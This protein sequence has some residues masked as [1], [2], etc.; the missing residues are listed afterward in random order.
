MTAPT[1]AE[2]ALLSYDAYASPGANR[3]PL[4]NLGWIRDSNLSKSNDPKTGF[5][6]SVYRN[7]SEIVVAFRGTDALFGADTWSGN[8]PAFIGTRSSQIELAIKAVADVL[9]AMAPTDHLTFTGHSLGGGLASVMAVFFD[10]TARV[11]ALAPF[12]RSVVHDPQ[13]EG[14]VTEF[15]V[16]QYFKVYE[17]YEKTKPHPNES[18][19]PD[20]AFSAYAAASESLYSQRAA[21]VSNI[22][23]AGEAVSL[24]RA[25]ATTIGSS[26]PPI[27]IGQSGLSPRE[28]HD[29][30][31]HSALV[32]SPN[33]R[34][35]AIALPTL[36]QRV[37]DKDL[38][39]REP[40]DERETAFIAK[41]LRSQVATTLTEG[42]GK[43][44]YFSSDARRLGGTNRD[45][46]APVMDGLVSALIEAYQ[47]S[48][49]GESA[50]LV[51][52]VGAAGVR[53]DLSRMVADSSGDL[54]DGK[55]RSILV[56]SAVALVDN[57][58]LARSIACS[59]AKDASYWTVQNTNAGLTASGSS[60]S[61][62][63]IGSRTQANV[64][65]GAAAADLLI[66]GAATDDLSGGA[67]AD[68]LFGKAGVDH[69]YGNENADYL[70]G[71]DN[72]DVLSGGAG[73]DF[74]F[75]GDGIDDYQ[76]L[77]SD[78]S[79]VVNDADG[80]GRIFIG[81]VQF[82]GGNLLHTA[83]YI[84][85][86]ADGSVTVE[87]TTGIS[88]DLHIRDRGRS[89]QVTILSWNAVLGSFGISLDAA[90]P[91]APAGNDII[92]DNDADGS[93]NSRSAVRA[94]AS[95]FNQAN[96]GPDRLDHERVGPGVHLMSDS[97]P[98]EW[99]NNGTGASRS[100]GVLDDLR[101]ASDN[102]R[103]FGLTGN[104][105]LEGLTGD[106]YL[107]GGEDD[108]LLIGGLGSDQIVGGA[109]S[110]LILGDWQNTAGGSAIGDDIGEAYVPSGLS[111]YIVSVSGLGWGYEFSSDD[112][113]IFG[114]G[115]G[116]LGGDSDTIDTGD[117]DDVVYA[118]DG[119][120]DI[121][122]GAGVDVL[123]GESGDDVVS[124]GDDGDF[125]FGDRQQNA[126]PTRVH[127][128]AMVDLREQSLR[129][130]DA[131]FP[132]AAGMQLSAEIVEGGR[133]V[134][135]YLLSPVQKIAS[136]A[137]VER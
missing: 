96:P 50:P 56:D 53:L 93:G 8:L 4:D 57:D 130:G 114:V 48:S 19:S 121:R 95:R 118:G 89:I 58:R 131:S 63:L 47:F 97:W 42:S 25:D 117:G 29:M 120:D 119:N 26:D 20:A 16:A 5:G 13:T 98:P 18:F 54:P 17:D 3:V 78:G 88:S 55:G 24:I 122:G 1:D 32:I 123:D 129:T 41:L 92:G 86:S 111:G 6:V 135:E 133:T 79:D 90:A 46:S 82:T 9:R 81:G 7:G 125:I 59:V 62:V 44:E 70:Y 107:D 60:A 31:L 106:D 105:L 84:W 75:G 100:Y 74:L 34:L 73:D 66:G 15:T 132:L 36:L 51:T 49:E 113:R 37:F 112:S 33:F 101:G 61:D 94:G 71:G 128:T 10:R 30:R 127:Y 115:G 85:R 43:L 27:E 22:Y 91:P 76:F 134:L 126:D 21:K 2:L 104:D 38:Y 108:D 87:L 69:L 83:E 99:V 12:R 137:G 14:S 68:V 103:L 35:A 72:D 116:Y 52:A 124:G 80:G 109:G 67:G 40:T 110:D 45:Q 39:E 102:D 28:L 77:N 23:V 136:E 65:N 11:F 64:L